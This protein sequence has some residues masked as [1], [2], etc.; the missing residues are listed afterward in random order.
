MAPAQ[1]V[2]PVPQG[3]RTRILLVDDHP[4]IREG[5]SRLIG[6]QPDLAVAGSVASA[7]LARSALLTERPDMVILDLSLPGSSGFRFI[8][9]VRTTHPTLPILILSMHAEPFN[10]ERAL[11]AGAT[12]YITKAD[13]PEMILD[14]IRTI[15]DGEVFVSPEMAPRLLTRLATGGPVDSVSQL[16]NRELEVFTMI[17]DG[18]ST[19]RIAQ[20][21]ALSIKTVETYRGNIKRKLGLEDSA[22][23]VNYAIRF[24]LTR[25]QP[26]GLDTRM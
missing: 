11:Q 20:Q 7:D 15:R 25:G 13:A 10:V 14:A 17:G 26:A 12:G 1:P 22:E 3:R 21:L 2:L 19:K 18:V 8:E 23:L 5:L 9:E 16:S 4:I 24:S 6:D